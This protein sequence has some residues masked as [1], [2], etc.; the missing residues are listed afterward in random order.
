MQSSD[1]IDVHLTSTHG[2][3]TAIFFNP[4]W[5]ES[6]AIPCL[7]IFS[8]TVSAPACW[9]RNHISA[10]TQY[11]QHTHTGLYRHTRTLQSLSHTHVTLSY[12]HIHTEITQARTNTAVMQP[13]THHHAIVHTYTIIHTR[14]Y[15]TIRRQH[16]ICVLDICHGFL[17]MNST[18]YSSVVKSI[19]LQIKRS[20]VTMSPVAMDKSFSC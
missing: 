7:Q 16:Q 10:T 2:R 13:Y 20:S 17:A 1:K 8:W 14:T 9:V 5:A 3:G 12:T 18:R 19:R 6:S 11:K 4:A 15:P